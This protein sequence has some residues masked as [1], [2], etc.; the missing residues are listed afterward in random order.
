MVANDASMQQGG[1]QNKS[2]INLCAVCVE[3]FCETIE[4]CQASRF[5]CVC[6]NSNAERFDVL[7]VVAVV[8]AL[9]AHFFP[10][11]LLL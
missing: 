8:I 4:G 3:S 7:N 1:L 6:A 9:S 5:R 11:E 2:S 10:L